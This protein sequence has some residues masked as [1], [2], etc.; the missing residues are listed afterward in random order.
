METI[1]AVNKED[2]R[3]VS[4]Y[5]DESLVDDLAI[6]GGGKIGPGIRAVLDAFKEIIKKE[7]QKI[8]A[9]VKTMRE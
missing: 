2:R 3:H 9:K 1:K 8:R 7:A 5:L 6:I 4:L